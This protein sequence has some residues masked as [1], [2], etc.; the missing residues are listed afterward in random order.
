MC[1][2]IC[3]S[4]LK[5]KDAFHII[6]HVIKYYSFD[7][8]SMTLSSQKYKNRWWAGLG[9]RL[10]FINSCTREQFKVRYFHSLSPQSPQMLH[11]QTLSSHLHPLSWCPFLFKEGQVGSAW[12]LPRKD[13][14]SSLLPN[15]PRIA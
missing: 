1:N 11:F 10:W 2:E 5:I 9:F 14:G 7:L 3:I 6:S 15:C 4:P 8:F 12:Q 13:P